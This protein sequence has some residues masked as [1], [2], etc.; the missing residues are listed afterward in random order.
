[1][2]HIFSHNN[3]VSPVKLSVN[4]NKEFDGQQKLEY[5]FS[6][7]VSELS[8]W[9]LETLKCFGRNLFLRLT[10]SGMRTEKC[11]YWPEFSSRHGDDN[12]IFPMFRTLR[13]LTGSFVFCWLSRWVRYHRE[14]SRA[15]SWRGNGKIAGLLSN[16]IR[17]SAVCF[18][19]KPASVTIMRVV[20]RV[21]GP[22]GYTQP[23]CIDTSH[24]G[25]QSHPDL[26]SF[27]KLYPS[28]NSYLWVTRQFATS[29]AS[30]DSNY[31]SLCVH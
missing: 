1:M 24:D 6:I 5:H 4:N 13:E 10:R 15:G 19:W 16:V 3:I 9:W 7:S 31:L 29:L 28:I 18:S 21:G 8:V 27:L 26:R 17:D 23:L 25:L 30:H 14:G 22:P 2:W 20:G 12:L 11:Y